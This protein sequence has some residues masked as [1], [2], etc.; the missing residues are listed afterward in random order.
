MDNAKRE[1][2]INELMIPDFIEREN[3]CILLQEYEDTGRS[4]LEVHLKADENLCIRNIDKK[5]TELQFFQKDKR[6]SMFKRVDHIIY[7]HMPGD[8]WKVHMIEMK[9]WVGVDK[10]KEIKGKFRAS[11]LLAQGIASMLEMNITGTHLYTTYEKAD[12][13]PSP[14]MPTGRRLPVG[15]PQVRPQDEW[16]GRNCGLNFGQRIPF[17]HHPIQMVRNSDQILTGMWEEH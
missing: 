1:F 15:L 14:V 12:L 6:K 5:H 8:V 16:E 17:I 3:N 10:W 11:Y 13:R 7:E 4:E 9:S 2:I